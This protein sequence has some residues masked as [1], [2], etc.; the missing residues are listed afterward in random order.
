MSRI[1]LGA[2]VDVRISEFFA[3][4][5]C[6]CS[7]VSPSQ[8]F[9]SP[10]SER[11]PQRPFGAIFFVIGSWAD[12]QRKWP[13]SYQRADGRLGRPR[14]GGLHG[15]RWRRPT[16]HSRFPSRLAQPAQTFSPVPTGTLRYIVRVIQ[17]HGLLSLC[18]T[19]LES[20][21]YCTLDP[22]SQILSASPAWVLQYIVRLFQPHSVSSNGLDNMV[23]PS[24]TLY[25][26]LAWTLTIYCT[27]D[28][29]SQS[30]IHRLLTEIIECVLVRPTSVY[31]NIWLYMYRTPGF[32]SFNPHQYITII[33]TIIVN[34]SI[35]T[36][37]VGNEYNVDVKAF[38]FE[39]IHQ[40]QLPCVPENHRSL[41]RWIRRKSEKI[42][43]VLKGI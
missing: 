40:K 29:A 14:L 31:T 24:Q 12:G 6:T 17:P 34:K 16:Q 1:F 28:P 32:G 5:I 15:S 35:F 22:V 39:N 25:A 3:N 10:R 26:L 18:S 30:L 4:V 42:R 43:F 36:I 2:E 19:S 20:A 7:L 13:H 37:I 8:K 33:L 27:S 38:R 41:N 9:L 21:I 11:W 23:Q